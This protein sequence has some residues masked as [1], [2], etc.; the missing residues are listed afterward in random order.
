MP[1][2][3][4]QATPRQHDPDQHQDIR[5]DAQELRD[6]MAR[7]SEGCALGLAEVR[8]LRADLARHNFDGGGI[9]GGAASAREL[10]HGVD[11]RALDVVAGRAPPDQDRGEHEAAAPD[12]EP[13]VGT[14]VHVVPLFSMPLSLGPFLKAST[15]PPGLR[16]MQAR[17]T[18]ESRAVL[19]VGA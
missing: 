8:R 19:S 15:M 3:Q 17:R 4:N 9:V 14:E 16:A 13:S 2:P 11:G 5:N 1:H 10:P 18:C 7:N 12:R 6:E